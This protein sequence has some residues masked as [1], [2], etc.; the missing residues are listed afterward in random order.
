[1]AIATPAG[2]GA[3]GVVR[4][5]GPD[6]VAIAGALLSSPAALETQPSHTIRKVQLV[7]RETE[8]PID[9][10]VCAVMRA[11]RSYT[12]E[13]VVELSCHGGPA[14]L[15]MVVARLCR[16]G[17]RLAEPG[18]FTRRAFV[19]GRMDLARAE[20]VALVITARTERAVTLAARALEGELGARIH[21]LR[22]ALLD[23]VAGLE[24]GLDFP[25][26]AVGVAPATAG[27]RVE[28]CAR[29]VEAL[30]A[31]ARR[32]RLVQD[33]VTIALVGRPN[34]GKSSL[35]NALLGRERAI[36]APTPGTTRDVVEGAVEIAGVPVRLLDTAGLATAGDPIEAEG[37]KRTVRALDES[38]VAL[39]VVDGSLAAT[40]ADVVDAAL[41]TRRTVVVRAKSDLPRH[42]LATPP[43]DAVAVSSVTGEGMPALL[44]R[45]AEEVRAVTG[46]ADEGQL[47]ATLRQI[48][49][50]ERIARAL[51]TAGA[52]LE[53]L[54]LEAALVDLRDALV[55]TSE[56]LGLEL[57]DAVVDRIF[58][59]FCVGK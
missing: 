35:L 51:R 21:A 7:D 13:D 56:L 48:D 54:P 34:A 50:L 27:R 11:P 44:A 20:A 16:A 14:L 49:A 45:L 39:L 38:D 43:A 58:A 30:L 40:D 25:E 15:A 29:D 24:V 19:N 55:A 4:L 28:Q 57:G 47:A 53:S 1:V 26:D 31:A 36:V 3:L 5:S 46:D 41:A 42:P 18:E 32:G 10:A 12:G 17:A 37:M 6:A 52:A 2:A 8:A 33:G 9:E 59:T 23:L 22:D